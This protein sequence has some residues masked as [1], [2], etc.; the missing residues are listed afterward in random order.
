[1][2]FIQ[3]LGISS[4]CNTHIRYCTCV[5]LFLGCDVL[6]PSKCDSS[7]CLHWLRISRIQAKVFG[8]PTK[9]IYPT[10]CYLLNDFIGILHFMTILLSWE[11][12]CSKLLPTLSWC[13]LVQGQ[14]VLCDQCYGVVQ[15][16]VMGVCASSEAATAKGKSHTN[17]IQR[18]VIWIGS[19]SLLFFYLLMFLF[20]SSYSVSMLW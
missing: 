5:D 11:I 10:Y 3:V 16:P 17:I 6:Y 19:E 18:T 1:M 20:I 7:L 4:T 13:S 15:Q 2:Q 14:W 8:N 9:I 12:N